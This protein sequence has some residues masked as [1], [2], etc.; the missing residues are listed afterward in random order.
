MKM[1]LWSALGLALILAGSTVHAQNTNSGDIRGIVTDPSGAVI[2]DTTVTVLDLEKGVVK[3]YTTNH[4]GLFD[5]GPIVTGQYKVSFSHPGF[6]SFVRSSLTLD[7]QTITID[8]QLKPGAV[9]QEVVVN[10]DVPLIN[11]EGGDQS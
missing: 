4:D 9:T 7:V 11:T 10:T 3:T 6:G 2:P 1:K 5:T 8:A